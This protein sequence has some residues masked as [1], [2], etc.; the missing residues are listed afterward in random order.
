MLLVPVHMLVLMLV[1]VV[2]FMG[3]SQAVVRFSAVGILGE[4]RG[5]SHHVEQENHA[6]G[7]ALHP[8]GLLLGDC[9]SCLGGLQAQGSSPQDNRVDHEAQT[10]DGI[11]PPPWC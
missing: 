1:P 9:G 3:F 7:P 4:L 11:A 6:C 10:C 5:A 2:M 8:D